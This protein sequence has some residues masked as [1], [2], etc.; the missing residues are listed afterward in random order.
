[1]EFNF[2]PL[3]ILL[4]NLPLA[5]MSKEMGVFLGKIIRDVVDID[6]GPNGCCLDR[7]IWVKILVEVSKPLMRGL[8]NIVE[9]SQ[10]RFE[11]WMMSVG[12]VG[13]GRERSVRNRKAATNDSNHSKGD[14]SDLF[15]AHPKMKSDDMGEV[16]S[17]KVK[18]WK[19]L[20][21]D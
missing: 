10:L 5:H 18:K 3:W 20:A 13:T 8:R 17:P 6:A 4:Y 7:F 16:N 9:E 14:Q 12:D 11:A 1:M 15:I 2:V 21:M 19:R